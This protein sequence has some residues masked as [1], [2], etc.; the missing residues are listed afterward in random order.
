MICLPPKC[1]TS[2]WQ[3]GMNVLQ[4]KIDGNTSLPKNKRQKLY[5]T[6]TVLDEKLF[7]IKSSGHEKFV[8]FR[9]RA[10]KIA[11]AR[12]PFSR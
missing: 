4:N 10:Y 12:N 9:N 3:R 8:K 5:N 2:N 1:G 11:N 6:L 7:N